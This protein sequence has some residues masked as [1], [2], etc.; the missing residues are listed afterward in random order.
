MN[1]KAL[2]IRQI[3]LAKKRIMEHRVPLSEDK[4]ILSS[5][6]TSHDVEMRLS[7]ILDSFRLKFPKFYFSIEIDNSDEGRFLPIILNY[8]LFDFKYNLV[9]VTVNKKLEK[10]SNINLEVINERRNP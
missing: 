6:V 2:E 1:S 5:C 9:L 8:K 10:Y 3:V 7:E 4:W